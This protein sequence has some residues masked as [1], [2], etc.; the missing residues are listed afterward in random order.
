MLLIKSSF[1]LSFSSGINLASSFSR[2]ELI[3]FRPLSGH[4]YLGHIDSLGRY[5][6]E[7]LNTGPIFN[8]L[9]AKKEK[10]KSLFS[11][12][13]FMG[14]VVSLPWFPTDRIYYFSE[15][16]QENYRK[17]VEISANVCGRCNF[18]ETDEVLT[19]LSSQTRICRFLFFRTIN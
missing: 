12:K 11:F 19:Q 15:I 7:T 1:I 10:E 17:R 14:P 4:L 18:P 9:E 2:P 6:S 5:R 3:Y 16:R 13:N 8:H